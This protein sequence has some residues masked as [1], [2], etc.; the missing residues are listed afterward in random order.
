VTQ[1]IDIQELLALNRLLSD[2]V[3]R[4]VDQLAAINTVA[5]NISQSLDLEYTLETA[6]QVTLDV[7]NAQAGGISLIDHEAGEVVLRAQRGWL[8]D[9]VRENPMRIPM[10][11]GMS[12]DVITNDHAVVNNNLDETLPLAVPSFHDEKFRSIAMVPMHARGKVIGIL[13]TMSSH[14]NAFDESSVDLLCGVADTVGVALDN[15]SLYERSVE[16]QRRLSAVLYSTADGIIAT[17]QTGRVRMVNHA[18]ETLLK[19][20]ANDLIGV[21]L[22]EANLPDKLCQ[23]LLFAISAQAGESSRGFRVSTDDGLMLSVMVSPIT[24]ESQVVANTAAEGWVIV[25][26]DVTHLHEAEVTRTRFIKAAA[27]DMRNPLG[28]AHHSLNMLRRMLDERDTTVEEVLTIAQTGIT[29]IQGLID[30]LLSLELLQS[31][32]EFRTETVDMGEFIY[33]LTAAMR[34]RMQAKQ[35]TLQLEIAERIPPLSIDRRWFTRAV[36][37]YLDNALKYTPEGGKITLRMFVRDDHVHIEVA[38]TGAGIAPDAQARVFERFYR[39]EGETS[40]GGMGLGLAIVR[41]VAQAHGGSVYVQ[42]KLGD[43]SVFGLTIAM[44][45]AP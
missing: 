23:S 33:E 43:G 8:R 17:D 28:A 31:S 3:K 7:T 45:P 2:Q 42:S 12:W 24:V 11:K 14:P 9:F 18:A 38:D 27:H 41:S 44:K 22:R 39:G 34:D 20:S 40:L 26:Q 37:N 13:S 25:L 4:Q 16:D 6:L 36:N 10:G 21:Q 35:I 29:R 19:L 5:A 32:Y 1:R 15:A 30:D